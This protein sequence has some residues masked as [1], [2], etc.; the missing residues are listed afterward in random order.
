M[1]SD[2]AAVASALLGMVAGLYERPNVGGGAHA[3]CRVLAG[4]FEDG[5][6]FVALSSR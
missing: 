6:G 3:E 5:V 2:R 4:E 1:L